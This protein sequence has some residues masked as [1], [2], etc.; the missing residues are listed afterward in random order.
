[1]IPST[2]SERREN[3]GDKKV[4]VW[5]IDASPDPGGGRVYEKDTNHHASWTGYAGQPTP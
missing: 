1:M 5:Y 2:G 3:M 4:Y